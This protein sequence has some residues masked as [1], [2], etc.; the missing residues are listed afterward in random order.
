MADGEPTSDTSGAGLD[1]RFLAQLNGAAP[2]RVRRLLCDYTCTQAAHFLGYGGDFAVGP[3]DRFM[4]LGFDS[5]RAVDFKIRLESRLAIQLRSTVL[6]DCPTPAS[7]VDHLIEAL[8]PGAS[9][10]RSAADAPARRRERVTNEELERL[11]LDALRDLVRRQSARL[12]SLEDAL[13]EPIAIVGMACRFPGGAND[14][15]SFWR[16]Q[17][18]GVDAISEVPPSRWAIDE[19]YDPDREKPGKMYT[20]YGGFLDQVDRFDARFF[21]ISPREA[22]QLDPQ[23]RILLEVTWEA[24]ERAGI[25]PDS[26][27]GTPTGV[28]VGTRGADYYQGHT[29]WRPEDAETYYATG[30]AISTLAGRIAYFLGLTGP[31]FALDTACSSSLVALHNA[32]QSLRRGESSA[33]LVAG[34]NLMLD[35][36]GT[37]AI[38]KASMLAED[39]RCKTFSAAADGYVRSEGC[40]VLVLK[41]LSRARM[42]GDR[43]LA[44]I[45]GTAINQDGASGGL[46][47]P[48][49]DAQEAVIRLALQNAGLE[50]NDVDYVEAHGTGTSLGDPIEVAALDAVF[51]PSRPKDRP[52]VV[53][54]VKTNIGHLE[55]AA[56]IAGLIKVILALREETIPP[57]VGLT[58]RNPHIPWDETVIQVPVEPTAWP[59]GE[60]PRRAGISSFGF[61]GTNAHAVIE[62]ASD[63]SPATEPS[64]DRGATGKAP[65]LFCISGQNEGAVAELLRL[66]R[67]RLDRERPP[68]ADACASVALGRAHL[69]IRRAFL[70]R[71]V[72]DLVRQLDVAIAGGESGL[73]G[74]APPRPPRVAFLFTGQGAQYAGMGRALYDRWPAFRDAL[75]RAGAALAD[76]VE[77]RLLDVLFGDATDR[78]ART[79]FT[80]PALFA[81]EFALSELVASFGIEPDWMIGHSVGEYAAACRAGVFSLD[82]A[83]RLIAARG[84]FMVERTVPGAMIAVAAAAADVEDRVAAQ[85]NLLSIAAINGPASVVVSGDANAI[86]ALAADLASGGVAVKRLDVS[87]AFHSPLMDPMLESFA[88]VARTVSYHAPASGFISNLDP[89]PATAAIATPDYWIR[90]VREPVRF[91]A[92]IHALVRE[93]VDVL[94][95]IG[96]SPTL[97]G[98]ARRFVAAPGLA[99][100]PLLRRGDDDGIELSKTLAEAYVRGVPLEW[101]GIFPVRRRTS[102]ALPTYPFQRERFW[103]DGRK[104]ER[105]TTRSAHALLGERLS[106]APLEER[107]V[108][109]QT[110]LSEHDPAWLI[111][112]RAFDVTVLPAAAFVEA[113]FAAGRERLGRDR[114]TISSV[115]IAAPILLDDRTTDVQ[116][117]ITHDGGAHRFKFFSRAAGEDGPWTEH[118]SGR[119]DPAPDDDAAALDVGAIRARCTDEI[120]VDDYYALYER[121]GL[122]YGESFRVIRSLR[123]GDGEALAELELPSRARDASPFSIH[124]VLLDGCFQSCLT[125]AVDKGHH[126]FYLPIGIEKVELVG[127]PSDRMSC[128]ARL[129]SVE[130]D[131]RVLTWD[132][133]LVTETGAVHVRV[134]G[135]RLVQTDR[136]TVL[137]GADAMRTLAHV[138]AWTPRPLKTPDGVEL[139]GDWLILADRGG[140]GDGLAARLE[141]HGARAHVVHRGE[142]DLA[143]SVAER[144]EGERALRGVVHLWSLDAAPGDPA[145]SAAQAI[146]CG[147]ALDLVH[148][149]AQH[150]ATARLILVT[151]GATSAAGDA[152]NPAGA[153][154]LGLGSVIAL[155]HPSWRCARV[156]LDATGTDAGAD[157]DHLA[158]EVLAP[159]GEAQTAWRRTERFAA[160]LRRGS[161]AESGE[162]AIPKPP[163]QLRSRGY[164]VLE[165]LAL[166]AG[167]RRAPGPGE[168]EIE[169]R[170]APLNFKDVLF[171]LG[172]LKDHGAA[173]R[174][175]DQELGLEAAG[176][177]TA[178]GDGVDFA[179]GRPVLASVT[180]AL[181]SHVTMPAY[182]VVPI[183]EGLDFT[184]AAALPTV[185]LTSLYAL[186]RCANLAPGERVLIHAAAGGVGQAAIQVARRRGCEVFATASPA[187]WDGLRAQGIEHV[188]SSRKPGFAQEILDRTGGRGVDVVLNS[189]PGDMIE[190]GVRCLAPNGRFVEIGKIDV[191]SADRMKEA[192]P[193][194]RYFAFDMDDVRRADPG[195]H[196]ALMTDL[197]RGFA[198]GTFVPLP[199]RVFPL[200]RAADAFRLLAQAKHVGKVVLR[201]PAAGSAKEE[202]LR[203]DASY[204]VTGGGGALGLET[205]RW[206]VERG[207]RHLVLCGRREPSD[208]TRAAFAAIERTGAR[209]EFATLD[210]SDRA[211]VAALVDRITPRLAGVVHAAGVIDDGMLLN[212]TFERLDTVLA[213]KARGAWNLHELCPNLDFFVLFSSMVSIVGAQGQG[214]YAAANAMLDAIAHHRRAEGKPAVSLGFGPWSGAGMAGAT[215]E[216][217]RGRFAE[218][219][220]GSLSPQQG[221]AAL[222]HA[223]FGRIGAHVGVLPVTW[224]RFVTQFR[225]EVPTFFEAL[226]HAPSLN[227]H[228]AD[229]LLGDLASLRAEEAEANLL[230]FLEG[231]LAGVLGF[232][233]KDQV[234]A[235]QPFADMGVD[236]LLAVD[237]RNRLESA[238]DRALPATLL[239]DHPDLQ[240]LVHALVTEI[241]GDSSPDDEDDLLAEIEGMSEEDAERWLARSDETNGAR[242]D[243]AEAGA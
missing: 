188:F 229:P 186:E 83:A 236:S 8:A 117:S 123:R 105:R 81:F 231:Q 101:K 49:R 235:T 204:L 39:G 71:D 102:V 61:S 156:D 62:E 100:L 129:R 91:E 18:D 37:I 77:P 67:D 65:E 212:Q 208:A 183:P 50:P 240:S 225:D 90:H 46:T 68:L 108:L 17:R 86:D 31:C 22:V 239:F 180:G 194:V 215:E 95:E 173:P 38:C 56:G 213:A 5:L 10:E 97:L 222:D 224:S 24:L 189:L 122:G 219:G 193:D 242:D 140:V 226:V 113:V 206:L 153:T 98:M 93:G 74:R 136:D 172:V 104:S 112:H 233:S 69:S 57:L 19:Y 169:V 191:W 196:H 205:T 141:R 51:G 96:P 241:R 66:H 165:N 7:L 174:S 163:F 192:R 220:I 148:R 161:T 190:E 109:Y 155:E 103:L 106:V 76:H 20:R 125:I 218:F 9:D 25:A 84:R 121:K 41:R 232:A 32:V 88:A 243:A 146:V 43:V 107:A 111:G 47:V 234:D 21:G 150:G 45:R 147:S 119:F 167:S 80:Q 135:H 159:D 151:R 70:A 200:A 79:D 87:H 134:R 1:D 152:V 82:D 157:A 116:L 237:L 142:G 132:I 73:S 126:E 23:H 210:V 207:A 178:V 179:L 48:S 72:D 203:D 170:A 168:V 128:H 34:I 133:D 131:G 63:A 201:F 12:L 16:I 55:P 44:V 13:R 202:R 29:S 182:A 110:R 221:L 211:Q 195:L 127:P 145:G 11:D 166:V 30:N 187:K 4:D 139:H 2:A 85:R 3:E 137:A 89:G 185:F 238:L 36:F 138:V 33:A 58:E 162:L 92:G 118:A 54:S 176:V 181:A 223:I 115:S 52:L 59:R 53:G 199:A 15:D 99:W 209:I 114:L 175:L 164:G 160:R 217:N 143:R 149:L 177:V 42:D 94:I 120:D 78:L 130:A 14:P 214:P 124:P 198:D 228:A 184:D 6:F 60:R 154:L 26:L 144:F 197:A 35:P 64:R 158:A 28:F 216:R 230:D 171:A 227:G 27:E 40:G 75:D